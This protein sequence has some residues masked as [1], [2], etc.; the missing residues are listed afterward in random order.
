[1]CA[2]KLQRKNVLK[3]PSE[4]EEK[5]NR[6]SQRIAFRFPDSHKPPACSRHLPASAEH[7]S[8]HPARAKGERHEAAQAMSTTRGVSLKSGASRR[9][10]TT[11]RR[12]MESY[13]S[14]IIVDLRKCSISSQWV[15]FVI[16]SPVR[17]QIF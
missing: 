11:E 17:S 7:S 5:E 14:M 2:G 15:L 4:C 3:T 12:A 8:A 16:F 9:L 13:L 6:E 10:E 1:M